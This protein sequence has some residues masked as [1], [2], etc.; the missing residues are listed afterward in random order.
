MVEVTVS[1]IRSVMAQTL[2]L[3]GKEAVRKC[4]KQYGVEK[5]CDLKVGDMKTF[6]A[7]LQWEAD[8]APA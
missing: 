6:L 2:S 5:L 1:E 3:A 4:L 8:N 7:S